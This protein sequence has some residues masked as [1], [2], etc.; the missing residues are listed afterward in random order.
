MSEANK[1]DEQAG[2]I[3]VAQATQLLMIS[4]ERLRQLAKM[5]YF[6]R[7]VKGRYNLVAVVQ[8]YI[9]FLKD[10]ERRTSKSATASRMQ[11]AKTAEIEMRLAERR[12]ELIPLDDAQA[13]IDVIVGKVRAEFSGLPARVTRDMTLRRSLEVET[14]A[15]LNR[16]AD[17]IDASAEYFEKGGELPTGGGADDA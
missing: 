10:D 5:E 9:K 7:A 16:I 3:T 11:D 12:R 1:P 14:D 2:T 8:G 17:A 4:D 13:A 6:K 15:S